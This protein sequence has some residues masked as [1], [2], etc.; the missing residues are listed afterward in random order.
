[1]SALRN[2]PE[3]GVPSR[4]DRSRLSRLY[5]ESLGYQPMRM[6]PV[7]FATSFLL[8][9]V[10]R[11]HD[12]E[13]L[14]K[15]ANPKSAE[16]RP[17]DE[18]V[19]ENLF[20]TLQE[21]DVL[22]PGLELAHFKLFR[23]HVNAAFDNDGAA[24]GPAFSPYST[25][26]CDYS[27]PSLNY[28][29]N[30]SK[31]HGHAGAFVWLVL[32]SGQLGRD[33]LALARGIA[34]RATG[35]AAMLGSPLIQGEERVLDQDLTALC[36]NPRT[37][38]EKHGDLMSPQTQALLRLAVNLKNHPTAFSLRNLVLGVGSWLLVY[39]LRRI[40]GCDQTV[41]FC[42]FAGE[43]GSRLRTQAAACYSRQL[44]LFGRSLRLWMEASSEVLEEDRLAFECQEEKV[45]KELE[46]HFR[47]FSVRIGWAQPR[48]GTP[49]KY[50]RPQPDT[51]RVLL[52][53][54]LEPGEVCVMDELATRLRSHW[55]LVL[56]LLPEDHTILR[57][58]GYAPLDESDLRTNREGF[59]RLAIHLGLAWEPS[60]G[61]VLFS[62]NPDNLL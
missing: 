12:L 17:G 50:F 43:S 35:P 42:D 36:G 29:A 16:K 13:W 18:Y 51:M 62:L 39:Q 34:E 3:G 9:L 27:T 10:G 52:M 8:A 58:H 32:N 21:M 30:Q 15:T 59:K 46:D 45:S 57:Q 5:R 31:N 40:P 24:M 4:E 33:F 55:Q 37:L 47:D 1:M 44:G 49:T 54:V 14:N 41:F 61:L 23:Q 28:L 6:K 26:G 60:D 7:H 25:F 22:T 20:I 38:C 53:S 11:C 19:A 56:G 48:T 2:T